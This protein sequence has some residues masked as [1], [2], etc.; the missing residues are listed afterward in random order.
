[1]FFLSKFVRNPNFSSLEIQKF[2]FRFVGDVI[3]ISTGK[4]MN[5]AGNEKQCAESY[6]GGDNAW[7]N[8]IPNCYDWT[9][10]VKTLPRDKKDQHAEKVAADV[11]KELTKKHA[12]APPEGESRACY[13]MRVANPDCLT[14]YETVVPVPNFDAT[15]PDKTELAQPIMC[16]KDEFERIYKWLHPDL[17]KPERRALMEDAWQAAGDLPIQSGWILGIDMDYCTT[18]NPDRMML[19]ECLHGKDAFRS[20]KSEA[21]KN[22]EHFSKKS[23]TQRLDQR[24]DFNKMLE[25]AELFVTPKSHR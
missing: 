25:D 19:A 9:L 22:A 12:V 6:F 11:Y 14:K 1:M 3:K 17:P 5:G 20:V 21:S 8:N 23:T 7:V 24:L 2:R 13:Y 16:P 4:A 15:K 18:Q 10:V